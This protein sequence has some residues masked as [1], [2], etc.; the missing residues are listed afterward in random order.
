MSRPIYEDETSLD[1]ERVIAEALEEKW[2]VDFWKLPRSY[3]ADFAVLRKGELIGWAEL[4]VRKCE[5]KKYPTFMVALHKALALKRLADAGGSVILLV[6]WSDGLFMLKP[7]LRQKLKIRIG[8][9]SDRGDPADLEPVV[10]F[11]VDHFQ[12]VLPPLLDS[13]RS[14]S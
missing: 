1:H 10:H 13:R 14:S 3:V 12:A 4:K 11:L 8:G 7:D 5:R 9:R 2:G 6:H